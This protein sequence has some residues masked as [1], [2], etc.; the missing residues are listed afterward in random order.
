MIDRQSFQ[1]WQQTPAQGTTPLKTPFAPADEAYLTE[2]AVECRVKLQS[3]L[4]TARRYSRVP[5][6]S[7]ALADAVTAVQ[8]ADAIL[9]DLETYAD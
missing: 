5:A 1:D 6:L 2:V 9:S 7:T 4:E 3:A 8:Q